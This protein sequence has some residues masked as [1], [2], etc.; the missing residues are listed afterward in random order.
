MFNFENNL[1][2]FAVA[3]F[4]AGLVA[5]QN[6]FAVENPSVVNPA[7]VGTIPQSSLR[8]GLVPTSN[9]MGVNGNLIITGNVGGGKHFRGVIPYNAI[10]DFGGP[11]GSTT[12]DN[13]HRWTAGFSDFTRYRGRFIPYYSPTQTVT[14][15][16]PGI[17]NVVTAQRP[18]ISY[19]TKDAFGLSGLPESE[20]VSRPL[21]FFKVPEIKLIP[22]A[23][24][25]RDTEDIAI[26]PGQVSDEV[27]AA[28]D[29]RYR[30]QVEQFKRNR[31]SNLGKTAVIGGEQ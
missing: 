18:K 19:K 9:A 13:F 14:T 20:I 11:L 24:Q 5:G 1:L 4:I 12:L 2:R 10:T 23:A 16:Q 29:A 21:S 15:S 6:A 3:F 31:L 8:S 27:K 17:R 30:K 22:T 7:G 28:Q 26:P 25:P